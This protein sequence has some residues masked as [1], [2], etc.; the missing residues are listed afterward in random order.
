MKWRRG[1]LC[2]IV[3]VLPWSS[4]VGVKDD[5]GYTALQARLG[6]ETPDGTGIDVTQVEA[7]SGGNYM[8]NPADAQFA[9]KTIHPKSGASGISSH[10]NTVGRNYYGLTVSIAPGIN[11]IDVYEAGHW[12]GSGFLR[13]GSVPPGPPLTE[14]RRVQNHSWIASLDEA[15]A[16]EML[17]R[18]DLVAARDGVVIVAAVNNGQASSIPR[19]LSSGH[20]MIVVGLTNGQ[21]SYG[22]TLIDGA[23]R[24][25]PDIVAP[26]TA[27]S[28]AAPVVSAAAAL[29]L[30][31]AEDEDILDHLP[32]AQRR[33][34][35]ALLTRALLL[36]GATKEPFSGLVEPWRKGFSVPSTDGSVPLDYRFGAGQLNID[37][38]HLILTAGRYEAGDTSDVAPIGWDVAEVSPGAPRRYFLDVPVGSC[39]RELSVIVSWN[40]QVS[41]PGYSATMADIDLFLYEASGFTPG[42]LRD[43]SVST[44][45]NVEHLHQIALSP[46]RYV[47]EV[48][49][50]Q[51]WTYA[52][53]WHA[54]MVPGAVADFD[55]DGDVDK[56]DFEAFAT[57]F[58]GPA[59]GPPACGCAAADFNDDGHVDMEDFAVFQRCRSGQGIPADPNCG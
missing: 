11:I 20:N 51:T 19:L 59:L 42:C 9:G 26:L 40:R 12:L 54:R 1:I 49:T 32:A 10:A 31:T 37:N 24:V 22:P 55:C 50:D 23:G 33:T 21:S 2:L 14:T 8:P 4:A 43:Q 52:L 47:I 34:A 38:S 35:L 13:Y 15:P 30:Q 28:W 6:P 57:C 25:K 44:V 7:P 18:A 3:A 58:T 46:G 53:A 41:T 27:T 39:V 48:T 17:R 56:A 36:A 29:L 16:T 5:V 45:D